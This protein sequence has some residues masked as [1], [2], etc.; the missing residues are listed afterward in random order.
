MSAPTQTPSKKSY[1]PT[2]AIAALSSALA[3]LGYFHVQTLGEVSVLQSQL[4]EVSNQLS[5]TSAKGLTPKEINE[6]V[7]GLQ[8]AAPTAAAPEHYPDNWVYGNVSARYTLVEMTDTECPFCKEHFPLLKSLV[9]SSAGQINAALLQVPFLGETSRNQANAIECAGDQGG[10]DAAWKFAQKVFDLTR[11]EGQGVG[12]PL[13][14]IAKEMG[15]D[16][17]RF[18]ACSE[19]RAVAKRVSKD[20]EQVIQLGVTQ[21][22]STL[23]L[24]NQTGKSLLLQ[25]EHASPA[26]ILSAIAKLSPSKGANAP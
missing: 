23:V 5:D 10:S 17:D 25:G 11:S 1:G 16:G 9:E 4:S 12:K 7:S 8:S 21:T 18:A 13:V 15:L 24:D 19:S 3:V 14:T 20:L 22:P 2:I 26:G 6:L